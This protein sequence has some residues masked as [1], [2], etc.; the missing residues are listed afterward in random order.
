[1]SH[2]NEA[3]RYHEDYSKSQLGFW[4]YI[5]TDCILFSVLFATYLVLLP[6]KNGGP[7]PSDLFSLPYV[8]AE[9]LLLLTSS[10]TSGLALLAAHK[11]NVKQ[12][13]VWLGFTAALGA[14]FVAMEVVEFA[15][16]VH[17]GHGWTSSA[18]M[19]GYFTLVGTHGLHVTVGLLWM[20]VLFFFV[21]KR[22]LINTSVK[23]LTLFSL[24]WHFLDIVWIFIFSVVY[25]IGAI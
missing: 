14:S 20:I 6:N 23:R 8:L 21:L 13:L 9:T 19:S 24:F 25:M 1:M 22:G 2:V 3:A 4:L 10:F 18:F 7:G 11:N 17:E 15:K 5:M 12:V 16:L